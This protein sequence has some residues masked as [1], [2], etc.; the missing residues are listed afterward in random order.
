MNGVRYYRILNNYSVGELSRL[1]G[2]SF[3]TI[4]S[5]EQ[6]GRDSA[7]GNIS[8][9]S[10]MKLRH[11][12]G[13]PLDELLREDL[14][15]LEEPPRRGGILGS[16][17]ESQNNVIAV[18]RKQNRLSLRRIAGILGCSYQHISDVCVGL[19]APEKYI[20]ILAERDGISAEEFLKIYG[21]AA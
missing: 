5:M 7:Y 17:K 15:D 16:E 10:Y 18:Y 6:V 11:F 2:V 14:P 8:S 19:T 21:G 9:G 12:F 3:A 4:K 1:T 13:V 20:R